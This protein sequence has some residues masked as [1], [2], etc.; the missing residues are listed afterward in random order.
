VGASEKS[1]EED[2]AVLAC[3]IAKHLAK[4]RPASFSALLSDLES[5]R[6]PI[7]IALRTLSP[8][9]VPQRRRSSGR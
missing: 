2:G 4:M 6:S 5:G 3:R 9:S 1:L 8:P 7:L